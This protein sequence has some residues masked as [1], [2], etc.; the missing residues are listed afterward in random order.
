MTNTCDTYK[1]KVADVLEGCEAIRRRFD[2]VSVYFES[3][4]YTSNALSDM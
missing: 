4:A 2:K 1:S 3:C